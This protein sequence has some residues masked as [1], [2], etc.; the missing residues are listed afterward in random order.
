MGPGGPGGPGMGPGGPGGPGM[1]PGGPG[2]PG[3]GPQ[4]FG[5]PGPRGN[6]PRGPPGSGP[7]MMM[8]GPGGP[9]QPR[10]PPGMGGPRSGGP[11]GPGGN[12]PGRFYPPNRPPGQGPPGPQ[13]PLRGPYPGSSPPGQQMRGPMM[14]NNAAGQQARP[15]YFGGPAPNQG[16][17]IRGPAGTT[18]R[19][20]LFQQGQQQHQMMPGQQSMAG[21]SSMQQASVNNTGVPGGVLPDVDM[22]HLSEE[23]RLLIES[24]MAKAQMEELEQQSVVKPPTNSR[25]MK[26]QLARQISQP[27]PLER[28]N[29]LRYSIDPSSNNSTSN[30]INRRTSMSV[31]DMSNLASISSQQQRLCSVCCRRD[32]SGRDG[33]PGQACAECR[34]VVCTTCGGYAASTYDNKVSFT[35]QNT[36]W[37]CRT[38]LDR[39]QNLN[40]SQQPGTINQQPTTMKSS[41]MNDASGQLMGSAGRQQQQQQQQQTMREYN[42][43]SPSDTADV[44]TRPTSSFITPAV[45]T[46]SPVTYHPTAPTSA[47][48]PLSFASNHH[49]PSSPTAITQSAGSPKPVPDDQSHAWFQ[50]VYRREDEED[51]DEE[52]EENVKRTNVLATS[53][54][55]D[56]ANRLVSPVSYTSHRP[57]VDD[58]HRLR[59]QDIEDETHSNE[60]EENNHQGKDADD[61]DDSLMEELA[62]VAVKEGSDSDENL[63]D[64]E[65]LNHCKDDAAGMMAGGRD[66]AA[67]AE[68]ADSS[69]ASSPRSATTSPSPGSPPTASMTAALQHVYEHNPGEVYPIAEEEEEAAS[70]TASDGVTSLRRR[71][72]LNSGSGI[73]GSA[74]G[75]FN[76]QMTTANAQMR[77]GSPTNALYHRSSAASSVAANQTITS[78]AG[79]VR[80]GVDPSPS[81]SSLPPSNSASNLMSHFGSS[82]IRFRSANQ[83]CDVA[84]T[85]T[86]S[87]KDERM[88]TSPPATG[89]MAPTASGN[90]LVQQQYN[91]E[92][93]HDNNTLIHQQQQQQQ[94]Q[95]TGGKPAGTIT[96]M[97]ADFSR[98][99]GLGSNATRSSDQTFGQLND[100]QLQQQNAA[101]MNATQSQQLQMQQQ[102]QQ[103]QQLQQQQMLQS[104]MNPLQQQQQGQNVYFSA[105][106][107][108]NVVVNQSVNPFTGQQQ[109]QSGLAGQQ[110]QTSSYNAV[111]ATN[112][113]SQMD[114]QQQQMA[115]QQ[116][117]QQLQLQ[118]QLG[119][120]R[121]GNNAIM[122]N[123]NAAGPLFQQNKQLTQINAMSSNAVQQPYALVN[124]AGPNNYVQQVAQQF[125]QSGVAAV[126]AS[127]QPINQLTGMEQANLFVSQPQSSAYQMPGAIATVAM[128]QQLHRPLVQTALVQQQQQQQLLA[129]NPQ[130]HMVMN[131]ATNRM[132][133]FNQQTQQLQS[134]TA[135]AALAAG[136]A[137][138]QQ[139]QQQQH[140]IQQ[141]Q[142]MQQAAVQLQQQQS[143]IQQQQQ[144]LLMMNNTTNQDFMQMQHQ[145]QHSKKM[146]KMGTAQNAAL[147]LQQ[148][149][150]FMAANKMTPQTIRKNMLTQQQQQQ[151]QAPSAALL[152]QS[153][154]VPDPNKMSHG[155][156]DL[157][158][159]SSTLRSAD[160]LHKSRIRLIDG[161]PYSP[162]GSPEIDMLG[163]R[164]GPA[165]H[166]FMIGSGGTPIT[167]PMGTP[168]G[169]P[170]GGAHSR[171]SRDLLACDS[172]D[173]LSETDSQASLRLRRKLPLLPPDQEAA[174]LPSVQKKKLELAK[175]QQQQQQQLVSVQERIKA[176][177]NLRQGSLTEALNASSAADRGYATSAASFGGLTRPTSETN[178]RQLA[179]GE[180]MASSLAARPGSALGLL[181]GSSIVNANGLRSTLNSN[182]TQANLGAVAR[183]NP[184]ISVKSE[185]QTLRESLAAILPPDLRHLVGAPS[186]SLVTTSTTNDSTAILSVGGY[187][188]AALEDL[189]GSP[190]TRRRALEE[191]L[192]RLTEDRARLRSQTDKDREREVRI[193]RELD[194][195]AAL[196]D[197][198]KRFDTQRRPGSAAAGL[199]GAQS[200][201]SSVS[202]RLRKSRGH[203]RQ[204]SDPRVSSLMREREESSDRYSTGRSQSMS[205]AKAY[206]YESLEELNSSMAGVGMS[207]KSDWDRHR[208]I[209][210]SYSGSALN[211]LLTEDDDFLSRKY[212]ASNSRRSHVRRSSDGGMT[213]TDYLMDPSLIGLGGHHQGQSRSRYGNDARVLSR[214]LSYDVAD[215]SGVMLGGGGGHHGNASHSKS[216]LL[217]RKPRSWHPSPYGSD[218]EFLDAE[219]DI[220]TREAKKQRIKAEIAR[221]RQQIEQN[222]RLHDELLRLSRLRE[223]GDVSGYQ[224][225]HGLSGGNGSGG[226]YGGGSSSSGNAARLA[227]AASNSS[228]LRSINDIL[229]EDREFIHR[230]RSSSSGGHLYQPDYVSHHHHV[231]P[232]RRPYHMS[233]VQHQYGSHSRGASPARGAVNYSGVPTEEERSMERLASTFR[234]EDYTSSLYERLHDFS[235]L[236]SDPELGGG[237]GDMMMY[238]SGS[239]PTAMPLL[240]D[241][242]SR[243][244]KLLED[245]AASANDAPTM[246]IQSREC[247][248]G[249]PC[250]SDPE[251]S[252]RNRGRRSSYYSSEHKGPGKRRYPFPTKRI[253]L[254]C[255]AKSTATTDNGLGMRVVGGLEIPGRQGEIGAF[256][257]EISPGGVVDTHGQVQEGDQV[258]EWNGIQLNGKSFEEVQSII[259]STRG[260]VEIVICGEKASAQYDGAQ[261]TRTMNVSGREEVDMNG[262]SSRHHMSGE[263]STASPTEAIPPQRRGP[264]QPVVKGIIR[265]KV[266]KAEECLEDPEVRKRKWTL[267]LG[268][269]QVLSCYD[270]R[271]HILY[272]TIIRARKLQTRRPNGDARPDPLVRCVLLPGRK[273]ENERRTRYLSLTSDP[274]WHQTM[275][276]PAVPPADLPK[277]QLEVTVWHHQCDGRLEFLGEFLLDLA[278]PGTIDEQPHWY[279]LQDNSGGLAS[280]PMAPDHGNDY[281]NG[282]PAGSQQRSSMARASMSSALMDSSS[283]GCHGAACTVL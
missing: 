50:S 35:D 182:L 195:F 49:R 210:T 41:M 270:S 217:S 178:L 272:V 173:T 141:Q 139:Q 54:G 3:M 147:E 186:T 245:L 125:E 153:S 47:N 170:R 191:E 165:A 19:P 253:L 179:Y 75:M 226:P 9:Q 82:A 164:P 240:P 192:H 211:R 122:V 12:G 230:S 236:A 140:S 25:M 29:E 118:Q 190:L 22:S 8:Q 74:M 77:I 281:S 4:R 117:Q 204:L 235:P 26:G 130:S 261:S 246:H 255:D 282:K 64:V 84:T 69:C 263:L 150:Q 279:P 225:N 241:M 206:E 237:V 167:T 232:T 214:G 156:G 10:G 67:D 65:E 213:M 7:R 193:R 276:Y 180:S 40:W 148:Q 57:F 71:A 128:D 101:K 119:Q 78:M 267:P 194:K 104:A 159:S 24:V 115:L 218:E 183:S 212:S 68:E 6:G 223:C 262:N 42:L 76:D 157:Y 196:R 268:Q 199:I 151:Q 252:N 205:R 85:S 2:G 160:L 97:L 271:A 207:N 20:G 244:R 46:S 32:I 105:D 34:T 37:L 259:S 116:Q 51:E 83:P 187:R 201:G 189:R 58:S 224:T 88:P 134:T 132:A 95:Q 60:S 124:T 123:E 188:T 102:Q 109:Q 48:S 174:L 131:E 16:P 63:S 15:P 27:D 30:G 5:G 200:S 219:D 18:T 112:A 283:S 126:I 145:A 43:T 239:G 94:Q 86:N 250:Y 108:G 61:S 96:G 175:T 172:P 135:A 93:P 70:P 110:L 243:S 227:A 258:L 133:M 181:Q 155:M 144:Q 146:R 154:I 280:L 202:S 220:L 273:V 162:S 254:T 260:E 152:H 248:G 251:E 158:G 143:I 73:E 277:R 266:P 184:S 28:E 87:F 31:T 269:V 98:A 13:G 176:Y 92:M 203:R 72:R 44:A 142:M 208:S 114:P 221:R 215:R 107:S 275:V 23:E 209:P 55:G 229:R 169:T 90:H 274:E 79:G 129:N 113:L 1:G 198:M 197:P 103:Q 185:D 39:R 231:S 59:Y 166:S 242:P 177:S 11:M 137:Q 161:R 36:V 136:Q 53:P 100:Q 247:D 222:S 89:M 52:E 66:G 256:V 14:A 278:N 17:G 111:F 138:Q 171:D 127:Q 257:T 91:N 120:Q 56:A 106:G 265:N 99:L 264:Q 233:S 149:Q 33:P 21:G 249:D 45:T 38:C 62:T 80:H 234:T 228:V 216:I 238:N 163:M 81:S 168:A 121:V